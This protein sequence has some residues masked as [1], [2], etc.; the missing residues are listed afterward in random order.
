LSYLVSDGFNSLTGVTPSSSASSGGGSLHL[1]TQEIPTG[2]I[3]S[4]NTS[5]TISQVPFSVTTCLVFR[6]G[7]YQSEATD[8]SI[9]NSVNI[10]P[11]GW[12]FQNLI[13]LVSTVS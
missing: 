8:Y 9:T 11:F 13:N 2:S 7:L 6:N 5:F 3:N 10:L 12:S 4:S 1:W